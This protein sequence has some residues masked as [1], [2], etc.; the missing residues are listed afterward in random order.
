MAGRTVQLKLRYDDFSSITRRRTLPSPTCLGKEVFVAAEQLME[1]KTEAGTRPVRL[2]GVGVSGFSDREDVQG[3]LFSS[4]DD[5]PPSKT[6]KTE[7]AADQIRKKLG[8]DA[9]GRGS[10]YLDSDID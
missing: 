3:I 5:A 1:L 4:V 2:I 9:I 6:E 7:R 10:I 8:P